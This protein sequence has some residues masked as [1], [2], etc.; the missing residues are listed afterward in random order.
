ML[1]KILPSFFGS[2]EKGSTALSTGG[3]PEHLNGNDKE[4][5]ANLSQLPAKIKQEDLS[6]LAFETGSLEGHNAMLKKYSEMSLEQQK[7]ALA[8]L[9]IRVNHAQASM[10]NAQQYSRKIAK[11]GKN[12]IENRLDLQTQRANIDGYQKALDNANETIH[13]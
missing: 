9:D 11:H 8:S 7:Q 3:L 13:L 2:N 4:T 6:K 10:Q 12:V 5:L 1:D